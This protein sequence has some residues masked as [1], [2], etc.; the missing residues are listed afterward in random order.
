MFRFLKLGLIK[1]KKNQHPGA[2]IWG[3]YSLDRL[4][5]TLCEEDLVFNT[6]F[7]YFRFQSTFKF[8]FAWSFG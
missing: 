3:Q 1:E 6:S 2:P 5:D 4:S 8:R 7:A